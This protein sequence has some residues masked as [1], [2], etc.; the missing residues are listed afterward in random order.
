MKDQTENK[1]FLP[2]MHSALHTQENTG[3]YLPGWMR[4]CLSNAEGEKSNHYD[5]M[6]AGGGS[7]IAIDKLL[8]ANEAWDSDN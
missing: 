4:G 6:R 8:T 2:L 1:L 7:P 5:T 3:R